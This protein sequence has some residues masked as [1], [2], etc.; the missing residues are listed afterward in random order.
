MIIYIDGEFLE[1]KDAK[2]SVLDHGYLY[3]DGVFEGIRTYDNRVFKLDEHLHRLYDSA[4]AIL[5][6]VPLSFDELKKAT[7]ETCRRNACANGYIRLVVSRGAGSL[8]LGPDR[9]PKASVVIIAANIELY[10]EKYYREGLKVIT[11]GTRRLS[12]NAFSPTVKSLNYLNNIMAKVEGMRAG[13]QETL[14]LN[15]QGLVAECSGDNIFAI[16]KNK[17][18]TPPIW[19]GALAGITRDVVMKLSAEMGLPVEETNM[20]RYDL[21]VADEIF[22]TGTGAEVVPVVDLDSRVI[23]DGKPGPITRK[24]TERYHAITRSEGTPI[25]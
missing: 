23:G 6:Q 17:I 10:P 24:I 11:G 5:L 3:G 13:A 21:Y 14:M 7:V 9:C 20:T 22:L 8:G 18:T 16:K 12:W 25:G 2:I 4:K 1:E 19:A 15:E